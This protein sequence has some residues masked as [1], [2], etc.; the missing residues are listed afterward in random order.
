MRFYCTS[1]LQVFLDDIILSNL[2]FPLYDLLQEQQNEV[3]SSRKRDLKVDQCNLE[4][5]VNWSNEIYVS[6][7][8]NKCSLSCGRNY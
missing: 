1:V 8:V 6:A 3:Y 7:T 4:H 5:E 2:R